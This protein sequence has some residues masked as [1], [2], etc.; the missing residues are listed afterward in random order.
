MNYEGESASR[1]SDTKF[2]RDGR[3]EESSRNTSR[4]SLCTKIER[5]S[6]DKTQAHLTNA[7]NH[8]VRL[9]YVPSQTNSDSN[10]SFH[11]EPR[12]T[13]ATW[14]M[15]YVWTTGKPK[16]FSKN[17]SFYDTRWY[18]IGSS[19]CWYKKGRSCIFHVKDT[20]WWCCGK[21]VQIENTRV[22]A[23]QNCTWIVR[24]GD[25]SKDIDA[26]LSKIEDDGE[27][28][29]RSETPIAKLWRTFRKNWNRSSGY[30]SK[31]INLRWRRKRKM[32][33]VERKR[34]S[35]RTETTAVSSTRVMIAHQNRH[36]KP[37]HPLSHQWHEV[38]ARREKEAS[39]AKV[40]LA[41]FF[42]NRADTI[43]KVVVRD[44]LESSGILPNV[45]LSNWIGMQSRGQVS[46]AALQGWR[47]T[48]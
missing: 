5:N 48:K 36:R 27:R 33:P 29:K 25:S 18:R 14:H 31:G 20:I 24:D 13:L 44:H 40:T 19:A 21:Y 38:K 16:S 30:E 10:F 12:Q 4:R 42:D 37:L 45:N 6:W 8:S 3:N 46:V 32:L 35:V 47:T 22:W 26:Q 15:E 41:E 9:S 2:S 28:K 23:T 7:G 39:E 1:N 11:A 43:W 17:S 34:A